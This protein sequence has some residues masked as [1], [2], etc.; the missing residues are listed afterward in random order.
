MQPADPAPR[1]SSACAGYADTWAALDRQLDEALQ[2]SKAAEEAGSLT[3]AVGSAAGALLAQFGSLL[4]R[5]P[6]PPV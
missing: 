2:L 3:G 5:R 6:E 4:G 1:G